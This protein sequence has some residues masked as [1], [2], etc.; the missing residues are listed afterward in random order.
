MF[1]LARRPGHF[2]GRT[3]IR[4]LI[5]AWRRLLADIV[6]TFGLAFVSTAAPAA[7]ALS[8][9]RAFRPVSRLALLDRSQTVFG[10]RWA[11][12]LLLAFLGPAFGPLRATRTALFAG[13]S[14]VLAWRAL[15]TLFIRATPS[16]P[17]AI[18]H[19]V[20][21]LLSVARTHFGR[22]GLGLHRLTGKPAE[23]LF[24]DRRL[25]FLPAHRGRLG[26]RDSLH[27]SLQ[28]L[29][30]RL[31][32]GRRRLRHLGGHVHHPVARLHDLAL[33]E[34]VVAQPG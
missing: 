29:R 8:F 30:L 32:H 15:V 1:T 26:G 4:G 27:R 28:S 24:H 21:A 19:V 31:L 34:F 6:L 23:N 17:S 2:G 7:A 20:A 18:A 11:L 16:A 12:L 3:R 13:G 14:P 5:S 33:V 10:T 9:A 22:L 25:G